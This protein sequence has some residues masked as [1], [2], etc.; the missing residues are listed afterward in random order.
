MMAGHIRSLL[1]YNVDRWLEENCQGRYYHNPAWTRE[2]FIEFEDSR[3]AMWFA[4][5]YGR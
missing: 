3:D 2:K 4:L 1:D 5:R